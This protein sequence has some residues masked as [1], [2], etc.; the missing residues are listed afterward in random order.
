MRYIIAHTILTYLLTLC[1]CILLN[2]Y[3]TK[4]HFYGIHHKW[5]TSSTLGNAY[6]RLTRVRA[7]EQK[8]LGRQRP[9]VLWVSCSRLKG[10][11]ELDSSTWYV[12][13]SGAGGTKTLSSGWQIGTGS[14][15]LDDID[16]CM[17]IQSLWYLTGSLQCSCCKDG[18]TWSR[19]RR[20]V[21]SHAAAF[22]SHCSGRS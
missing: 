2:Y 8:L 17:R 15:Q 7:S 10:Q 12:I 16:C 1:T 20:V 13:V 22:W 18:V 3:I 11:A 14:D 5:S 21:I 6:K 9:E 4:R 19:D